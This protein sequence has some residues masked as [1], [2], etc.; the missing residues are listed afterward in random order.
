MNRFCIL[1]LWKN[2][3]ILS[4][5]QIH[6]ITSK[7]SSQNL[8]ESHQSTADTFPGKSFILW[9][10]HLIFRPW[11]HPSD[12]NGCQRRFGISQHVRR[13][14]CQRTG[15]ASRYFSCRLLAGMEVSCS[16]KHVAQVSSTGLLSSRCCH[17]ARVRTHSI[18]FV[19]L[20]FTTLFL[21][22]IRK[23]CA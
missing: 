14:H 1:R 8:Q 2:N 22:F 16:T 17:P 13:R 5:S 6:A 19:C 23:K 7:G 21:W 12:R 10:E 15:R 9:I 4:T 18:I 11:Y 3:S 20:A